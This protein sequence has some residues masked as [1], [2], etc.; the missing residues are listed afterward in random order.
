MH[1]SIHEIAK[2]LEGKLKNV[3]GAKIS[4]NTSLGDDL[5]L[6]SLR[7]IDL[8]LSIEQHFNIVFSESDLEPSTLKSVGDLAALVDRVVSKGGE[9]F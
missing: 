1:N 8:L 5:G 3:S 4:E 2:L 9:Q 7:L 6:D